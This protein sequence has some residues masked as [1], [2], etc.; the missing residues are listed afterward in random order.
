VFHPKD[1]DAQRHADLRRRQACAIECTHRVAH[2]REKRSQ[3]RRAE[4]RDLR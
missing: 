2:V 1:H 3:F 4:L